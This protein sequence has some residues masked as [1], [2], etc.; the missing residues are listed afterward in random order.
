MKKIQFGI[1]IV[2]LVLTGCFKENTI[3]LNL[4]SNP[5]KIDT[6]QATDSASKL[7]V[8][9]IFEGLTTEDSTG[10][11]VPAVAESWSVNGNVWTFNLNKNAKWHNGKK[12]IAE[13]FIVAWERA[14]NSKNNNKLAYMLYP[15]K[16]AMEYNQGTIIDFKAVGV[17]ALSESILQV[18][19][20]TPNPYFESLVAHPMFYPINKA[21]YEGHKEK[22][23]LNKKNILGNGAYYIAEWDT[24]KKIILKKSDKYVNEK[25]INIKNI[26]LIINGDSVQLKKMYEENKIDILDLPLADALE[27]EK[28]KEKRSFETGE[29]SYIQFNVQNRVFS[30]KKIRKAI[31]MAINKEAFIELFQSGEAEK[32]ESF[33]PKNISGANKS[34]RD[35]YKQSKYGMSYNPTNAKT[36]F[37][38]GLSEM[39]MSLTSLKN[40]N[41]LV[42][43]NETEIKIG[44]FIKSQLR[45]NLNLDIAVKSETSQMRSQ[46]LGSRDYDFT[47]ESYSSDVADISS[48]L[49]NWTSNNYKNITGWSN[50]E[51]EIMLKNGL[52]EKDLK[53]RV[54]IFSKSEEILMDE[55][56]IAPI[57][58]SRKSII[59]K[60]RL[61]GV[62]ISNISKELDF[63]FASIRKS[64]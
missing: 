27:Y 38:E 22:Y 57:S 4:F 58:F 33:I 55:L 9:H 25:N 3:K 8:S 56:P 39:G 41:L 43:S 45:E 14:L 51:Y 19:L 28:S 50:L 24:S 54:E 17:K 18:E 46:I 40:L 2:F 11:I 48:Y 20:N 63:K 30:N 21:F 1:L 7:I 16:G 6:Q 23:G 59:I 42:K 13:D 32:A 12:V 47:F 53:K 62:K 37:Q 31:A 49:G 26:N 15:I 36:L 61:E 35:E 34:F 29:V 64:K 5:E 52:Q 60:D 10:R 44:N